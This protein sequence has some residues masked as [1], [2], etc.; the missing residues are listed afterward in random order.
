MRAILPTLVLSLSFIVPFATTRAGDA[1]EVSYEQLR[2]NPKDYKNKDVSYEADYGGIAPNF[3]P[4]MI[5]SGFDAD[6]HLLL[7]VGGMN[8]PVLAKRSDELATVLG[9]LKP[10]DTVR[11]V[12]KVKE[13]RNQSNR[14]MGS[15]YYL[16]L[17][18]LTFVRSGKDTPQQNPNSPKKKSL[19]PKS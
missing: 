2:I 11:V 17:E 15:P 19:K 13:F 1:D 14:M 4:Y 8:L 6:D 7:G 10:G 9:N 18:K 12:G 16:E 5:A 3:A